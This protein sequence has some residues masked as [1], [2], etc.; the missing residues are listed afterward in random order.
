MTTETGPSGRRV[1]YRCLVS[2]HV[3]GVSFRAATR[4]QAE[5]L[6]LDGHARNLSDG[7]VE[8]LVCGEASAVAQLREWL[9]VGPSLARVTDVICEPLSDQPL[10]GFVIR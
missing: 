2:G 4:V 6:G 10:S 7:R 5:R 3:Q 9:W 1:C 8:V